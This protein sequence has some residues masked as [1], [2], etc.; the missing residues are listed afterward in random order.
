MAS[1]TYWSQL[2]P[3]PRL[4]SVSEALAAR[5]RDPAWLLARQW[6]LGEFEGADAGSP[7]FARI[8]SRADRLASATVGEKAVPLANAQLLEPLM[9]AEPLAPDLATRVEIG[10]TFEALV[11]ATVRDLFRGAYPIAPADPSTDPATARFLAVC[12]GRAVDGVALYG[13]AKKA[14]QQNQPLPSGRRPCPSAPR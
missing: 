8:T 12:A 3:S 13:A 11:N 14:Q 7:A 1:L 5:V 4:N 9:E 10:Q 2:Q 6:Q